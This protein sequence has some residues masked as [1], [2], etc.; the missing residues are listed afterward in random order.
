MSAPTATWHYV[1]GIIP[2][3]D[4]AIFDS[5][6]LDPAHEVHTVV[7]GDLSV[8]TS[9]VDRSSLQGLERSTAVRYLSAH[10]RVLETVLRDYPVLPV[11]FGTTLPDEDTLRVLL[12]QGHKLLHTTL[13]TYANKQQHEVVVLWD[14]KQ[15][16]QEISAEEP[17]SALRTQIA[18]GT[19]E[20]TVNERIALGQLVHAA[21][22]RRSG[23]ISE[24]V[25]VRLRDLAEDLIINPKMDDSMVVNV[26]LLLDA[27][28]QA[29]LDERLEELDSLFGGQLQIRCVGPLP[30]YSFATL[31]V[32]I[33]PFEAIDAARQQLDL[34]TEPRT[35]EIKHAY[36]QKAAQS[37]PDLNPGVEYNTATMEALSASYRLLSA[38]AKAQAPAEGDESSDWTCHL[39]RAAVERTL[40]LSVVR[41]ERV[42]Q[43]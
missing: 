17:I 9:G 6:G 19:A 31:E 42:Q 22:Q 33:L 23:Q 13:N 4:L 18:G 15:V 14:L 35:S 3:S 10:Q 43:A 16:F 8:V 27:T 34:T 29:D 26:A 37:H 11:K 12:N 39:D 25:V 28:R 30:P 5:E 20:E 21:L 7:E 1:Y 38:L 24:Q 36:R 32:Q 40:L 2:S 41:Q